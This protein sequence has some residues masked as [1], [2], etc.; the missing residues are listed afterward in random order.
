MSSETHRPVA[1]HACGGRL[2]HVAPETLDPQRADVDEQLERHRV[3]LT[4]YCYRMLGSAPDAE[5][6]V[7]ETLTRAW[8]NIDR[9]EGRAA[10]RTWLYKIATNVCFDS[11]SASQKRAMPIDMGPAA[12]ATGPLDPPLGETVWVGP[13]PD[14]M[15]LDGN[16]DPAQLAEARESVRLAFIAA[17]QHLPPR[18]RAVLILR[19]VLRWRASEVGD[20]LHL[21][22]AAV[23]S[24]LQRARATLAS[25]DLEIAELSTASIDHAS[26]ELLARYMD[27]F[28][29]YD[30]GALAELLH[31]DAT[32][33]MPPYPMWLRGRDELLTW[34]TG[35]GAECVGSRLVPIDVNGQAGFAQYRDGGQTPWSIQVPV[36]R[37]G[38]VVDITYFLETDGSLFALFGLPPKL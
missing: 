3:E 27:A 32:Q 8:R 33:S 13:A 24:A 37:D 6:A 11:L 9:F 20:L 19:D 15:V 30:M 28:E 1:L 5:D 36:W 21:S 26:Q 29:R 38:R 4:G 18:Q 17:L 25:R 12:S 35:A 34:M 7:Q 2:T 22:V 14:A 23:N 31:E 16:G 10:L